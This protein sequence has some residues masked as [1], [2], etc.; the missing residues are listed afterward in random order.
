LFLAK[1]WL[2]ITHL[3]GNKILIFGG[4]KYALTIVQKILKLNRCF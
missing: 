4:A 3:S 2:A 1:R